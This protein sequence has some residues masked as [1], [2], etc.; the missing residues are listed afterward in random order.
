MLTSSICKN[1]GKCCQD[2]EMEL[3]LKDIYQI[4]KKNP[5]QWKKEK[6]T[7]YIDGFYIL[8][9]ING[10]C[11]FYDPELKTCSI[12]NSRPMGCRYYPLIFNPSNNQCSYDKDCPYLSYFPKIENIADSCVKLQ[13][14][15]RRELLDTDFE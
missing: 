8:K 3:S 12:Y 2:T 14:W 1:C 5:Y 4:E 11:V 6:F 7:K 9:N 10:H 13:K 15:V